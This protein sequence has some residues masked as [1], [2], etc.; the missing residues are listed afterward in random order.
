M[1]PPQTDLFKTGRVMSNSKTQALYPV[2][3]APLHFKT[4][5]IQFLQIWARV[6]STVWEDNKRRQSKHLMGQENKGTGQRR[7]KWAV[8][9]MRERKNWYNVVP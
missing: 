2:Q 5:K 9:E 7:C 1:E 8:E 6:I 3:P 4:G